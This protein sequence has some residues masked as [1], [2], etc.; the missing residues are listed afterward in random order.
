MAQMNYLLS[1][2]HGP[3]QVATIK[4][5]KRRMEFSFAFCAEELL[6][7]QNNDYQYPILFY[8]ID[9]AVSL[10]APFDHRLV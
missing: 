1:K 6:R 2:P 5:W 8:I 9:V 7:S 10:E 3:A 4:E